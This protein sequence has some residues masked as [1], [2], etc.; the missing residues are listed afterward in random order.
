[1]SISNNVPKTWFLLLPDIE[2]AVLPMAYLQEESSLTNVT[3]IVMIIEGC[4]Y[5]RSQLQQWIEYSPGIWFC[6]ISSPGT[7]PGTRW[8]DYLTIPAQAQVWPIHATKPELHDS[9]VEMPGSGREIM[10]G[11]E[12]YRVFAARKDML[13]YIRTLITSDNFH[14]LP[15]LAVLLRCKHINGWLW[16]LPLGK[17]LLF[18]SETQQRQF[19]SI[20]LHAIAVGPPILLPRDSCGKLDYNIFGKDSNSLAASSLGFYPANNECVIHENILAIDLKSSRLLTCPLSQDKSTI[21]PFIPGKDNLIQKWNDVTFKQK[22]SIWC[23]MSSEHCTACQPIVRRLHQDW[24]HHSSEPINRT[25]VKHTYSMA[26][27]SGGGIIIDWRCLAKCAHCLFTCDSYSSIPIEYDMLKEMLKVISPY[28]IGPRGLHISGGEP[29]LDM[30][31]LEQTIIAFRTAGIRIEFVETNGFWAKDYESA[32]L[33]LTRLRK[34]G[35]QRIRLSI[36]PFHGD[37]IPLSVARDAYTIA[38]NIFGVENVFIFDKSLLEIP[39][40]GLVAYDLCSGGRAGYMAATQ[41]L[42]CQPASMYSKPCVKHLFQSTHAHFDGEGNIIPSVCTGIRLG[43]YTDLPKLFHKI[44]IVRFPIFQRLA[45]GGPASLWT[46]AKSE[47]NIEE[48]SGGFVGPC[49]C[50]VDVRRRL[51]RKDLFYELGPG[52]FY[53]AMDRNTWEYKEKLRWD[54]AG[55]QIL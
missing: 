23:K 44:D 5:I 12:Q 10:N 27:I 42:N 47:Y 40:K 20:A 6:L 39:N 52:V 7:Q 38:C 48:P 51:F 17:P 29:F 14:L 53:D 4:T 30:F 55:S 16:D 22:R 28:L 18:L 49:H 21:V 50:C 3:K 33:N 45:T 9:L 36:S 2:D 11:L 46:Y 37:F 54:D 43:H 25:I 8:Q 24:K 13:L 32:H 26:P 34:A 1:M 35:L 41:G 15:D 31:R 19:K